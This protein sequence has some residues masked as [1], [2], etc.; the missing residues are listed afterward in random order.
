MRYHIPWMFLFYYFILINIM[1]FLVFGIDKW[2]A[3]REKGTRVPENM[4][5]GISLFGGIIGGLLG[6]Y[7]FNHKTR[8]TKF[9]L[10]MYFIL[11][12]Y[13]ILVLYMTYKLGF[14]PFLM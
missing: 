10:I 11:V 2:I 5:F 8:K 7:T 1:T 9:K 13:I 3:K 6:I 12:L 14:F 4:L